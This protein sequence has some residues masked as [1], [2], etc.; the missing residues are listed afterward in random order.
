ME[1]K[2]FGSIML[3]NHNEKREADANEQLFTQYRV[4]Q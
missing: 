2:N 4:W 1:H 3:H